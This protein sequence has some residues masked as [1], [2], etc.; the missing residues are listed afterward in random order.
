MSAI[1]VEPRSARLNV[2]G[3]KSH[4]QIQ[5]NR[6]VRYAFKLRFT[7]NEHFRFHPVYGFIEPQ[8]STPLTIRR[9]PADTGPTDEQ[10]HL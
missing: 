4:H 10:L 1:T 5:N 8:S 2:K 3:G 7:D 9:I 6:F